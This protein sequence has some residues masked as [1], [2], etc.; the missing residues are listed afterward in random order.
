VTLVANTTDISKVKLK[1]LN[2]PGIGYLDGSSFSQ[3][4]LSD[5]IKWTYT[6]INNILYD[7]NYIERP[8]NDPNEHKFTGTLEF[9]LASGDARAAGEA[10]VF[11]ADSVNYTA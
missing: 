9:N 7:C 8:V 2:I 5:Q 4:V 11:D 6:V 10:S 3:D 1:K